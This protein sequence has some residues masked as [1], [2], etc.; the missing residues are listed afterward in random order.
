MKNNLA[1][2]YFVKA[3]EN[4]PYNLIEFKE[5]IDYA[6]SYDD[7]HAGANYLLGCYNME[8]LKDY[9]ASKYYFESALVNDIYHINTYIYYIDISIGIN[10]LNKAKTLIKFSRKIEGTC[11]VF[12]L[13]RESMILEKKEKF[14]RDLLKLKKARR[15][16][17]NFIDIENI[18]ND[19][20]RIKAKLKKK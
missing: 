20:K 5:A 2:S 15:T 18:D 4:Y 8:Y 7:N 14:K 16:S 9:N 13:S 12:I 3:L 1:D 17:I 6:I 19:L 10:D 11:P